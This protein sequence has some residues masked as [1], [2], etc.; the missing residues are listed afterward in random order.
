MKHKEERTRLHTGRR[1]GKCKDTGSAGPQ[2]LSWGLKRDLC[3]ELRASPSFMLVPQ[4]TIPHVKGDV[5]ALWPTLGHPSPGLH[6]LHA[7]RP[8]PQASL[9]TPAPGSG[10]TPLCQAGPGQGEQAASLFL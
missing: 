7:P 5:S 6:C 1:Q 4:V 8:A 10:R 9:C 3:S 2:T